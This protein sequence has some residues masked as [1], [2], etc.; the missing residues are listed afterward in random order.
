VYTILVLLGVGIAIAALAILGITLQSKLAI[1][2]QRDQLR[3]MSVSQLAT[4]A[5]RCAEMAGLR[6]KFGDAS[7]FTRHDEWDRA[8]LARALD[9]L[10]GRLA[11]ED[12]RS[13]GAVGPGTWVHYYYDF[14][15]AELHEL[16]SKAPR[17]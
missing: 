14:G 17:G 12:H 11:E 1:R 7:L 2:R 6:P 5:R 16:V 4:E 3:A 13:G 15:L 10:Y 9:E 8:S